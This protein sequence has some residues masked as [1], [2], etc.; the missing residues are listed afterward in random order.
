MAMDLRR[1]K[2]PIEYL[3][4]LPPGTRSQHDNRLPTT[5]NRQPTTKTVKM[6]G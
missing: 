5:D 3:Q 1:G 2:D 6:R 4:I